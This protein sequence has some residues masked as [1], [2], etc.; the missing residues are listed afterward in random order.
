MRKISWDSH[1]NLTDISP[2]NHTEKFRWPPTSSPH[3]PALKMSLLLHHLFF[4]SPFGANTR[5]VFA[6]QKLNPPA[7][8]VFNPS[9]IDVQRESPEQRAANQTKPKPAKFTHTYIN[10]LET[11]MHFSLSFSCEC[12][13]ALKSEA[14]QQHVQQFSDVSRSCGNFTVANIHGTRETMR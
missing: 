14:N 3:V 8:L 7:S 2:T 11:F 5:S 12:L 13:G 6:S 10:S 1:N 4:T 9:K